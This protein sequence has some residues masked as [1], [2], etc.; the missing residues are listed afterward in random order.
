MSPEK[1]K[2]LWMKCA[3]ERGSLIENQVAAHKAMQSSSVPFMADPELIK[4]RVYESFRLGAIAGL[5]SAAA[6]GAIGLPLGVPELGVGVGGYLGMLGGAIVGQGKA[7]KQYLEERGF[8]PKGINILRYALPDKGKAFTATTIL[9][10]SGH[11]S[12]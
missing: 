12:V 8:A 1:V 3:E 7:N 6:G 4:E 9:P 5:L 11:F 2:E 10:D